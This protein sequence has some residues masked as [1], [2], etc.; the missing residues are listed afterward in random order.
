MNALS[1]LVSRKKTLRKKKTQQCFCTWDNRGS[2]LNVILI[3]FLC[4]NTVVNATSTVCIVPVAELLLQVVN[5]TVWEW[6]RGN[7][8]Q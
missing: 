1:T 3:S 6:C 8:Y 2:N 7:H 5:M 4:A